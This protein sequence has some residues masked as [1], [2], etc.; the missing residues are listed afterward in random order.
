MHYTRT[1]LLAGLLL[2][3]LT[4][5][6]S[7]NKPESA[8]AT[9]S[10]SLSVNPQDEF[11]TAAH[12]VPFNGSPSD[13]EL[14]AYPSGWCDGLDA[15]HSVE[16]LFDMTGGGELYPVG[17]EW[18]TVKADANAL[19]VAGVKAY[20]PENSAVVAEELRASGEY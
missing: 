18:G 16:W 19:L 11:L 2:A 20:C 10:A 3:G 15:G 9:P 6:G 8:A 12:N 5:C 13:D 4:A 14:L 17:M 1:A 7:A